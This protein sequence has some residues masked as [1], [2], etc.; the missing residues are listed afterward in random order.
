[1][2]AYHAAQY[3]ES[4]KV[5]LLI[6]EK[7]F[8]DLPAYF[9]QRWAI[10]V[11]YIPNYLIKKGRLLDAIRFEEQYESFLKITQ[12]YLGQYAFFLSETENLKKNYLDAYGRVNSQIIHEDWLYTEAVSEKK[13]DEAIRHGERVIEKMPDR[14]PIAMNL[15]AIYASVGNYE[16]CEEMLV[17][18]ADSKEK[19]PDLWKKERKKAAQL[20]K[21]LSKIKGDRKEIIASYDCLRKA[22][23]ADPEIVDSKTLYDSGINMVNSL[24]KAGENNAAFNLLGEMEHDFPDSGR[25]KN[26]I[27]WHIISHPGNSFYDIDSAITYGL[28]AQKIM[29]KE[30]DEWIDLVYDTLAEAYYQKKDFTTMRAYEDL[31]LQYAP[32]ERKKIYKHREPG[33]G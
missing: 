5:D 21:L 15:S 16:K 11:N 3:D 26:E 17:K 7:E 29:E 14:Y 13:M 25:M 23:I 18:A 8:F 33:N 27:A 30:K 32:P 31:A 6:T 1:M 24:T 20:Y 19:A 4:K 10:V 22:Q 12:Y 28:S 2:F 9:Q